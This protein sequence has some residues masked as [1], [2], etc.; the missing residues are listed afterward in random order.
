MILLGENI[1]KHFPGT[2]RTRV[3]FSEIVTNTNTNTNTNILFWEFFF[4]KT[5]RTKNEFAPP[6][7]A[8]HAEVGLQVPFLGP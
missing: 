4:E 1:V 5:T 3:H 6:I 8:A 7:H 2:P